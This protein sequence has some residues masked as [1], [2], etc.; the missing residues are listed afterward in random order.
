MTIDI[1][2]VGNKPKPESSLLINDFIK[3]L[4][5]HITVRWHYIRHAA[6]TPEISKQHEA[7]A[8]LKIVPAKAQVILLDENG[9]QLSS[10]Q[11]A[12]LVFEK[13][14]DCVFIIGGAYGVG[15]AVKKRAQFTWSLGKLVFP[16]QLVRLILAE[17]LY[18]A[19]S[20]STGHPYHH[21]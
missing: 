17:Q 1:I 12:R 4:P 8:I 18:R 14:T 9:K 11:L 16:H 10:P 2:T 15:E 20:I 7:E 3:R 6:G 5:K 21:A 19:F 13:G